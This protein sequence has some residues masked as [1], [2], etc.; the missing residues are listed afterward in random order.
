MGTHSVPMIATTSRTVTRLHLAG[1]LPPGACLAMAAS[2]GTRN[3]SGRGAPSG[4]PCARVTRGCRPILP[5]NVLA[6]RA[7]RIRSHAS[8]ARDRPH[9]YPRDLRARIRGLAVSAPQHDIL[10]Y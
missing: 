3:F 7:F 6:N 9:R 4:L 1:L 2:Q 10:G 8:V 5:Y